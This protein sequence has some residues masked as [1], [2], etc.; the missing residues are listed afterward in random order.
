MCVSRYSKN[1]IKFL[2]LNVSSP[3]ML[4]FP[5]EMSGYIHGDIS[6]SLLPFLFSALQCTEWLLLQK[7]FWPRCQCVNVEQPC[8]STPQGQSGAAF[9]EAAEVY[10]IAQINTCTC[11]QIL[12][13]HSQ[14][15][16]TCEGEHGH[17]AQGEKL[18]SARRKHKA[19]K[20]W[21]ELALVL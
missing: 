10:G 8:W 11:M 1:R 16:L 18:K 4:G 9:W 7:A 14:C 13:T 3:E 6:F 20:T 15:L 17:R 5:R 2:A 19:L 12:H 21:S